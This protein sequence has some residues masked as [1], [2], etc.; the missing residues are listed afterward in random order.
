MLKGLLEEE[1]E[2]EKNMN[3]KMVINT[4]ISTTL[5]LLPMFSS[6]IFREDGREG[7]R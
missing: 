3:N 1:G 6:R 7:E 2:E 4:H 5:I